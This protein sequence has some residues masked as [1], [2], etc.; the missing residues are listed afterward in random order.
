MA[1]RIEVMDDGKIEV[2]D[3]EAKR[4]QVFKDV[5]KVFRAI[6]RNLHAQVEARLKEQETEQRS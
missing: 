3:T 2:Y 5:S 1:I 4:W 6:S